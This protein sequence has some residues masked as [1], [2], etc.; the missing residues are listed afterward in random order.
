MICLLRI[1][2]SSSVNHFASSWQFGLSLLN[3][4]LL[5][6]CVL[7]IVLFLLLIVLCF[8]VGGLADE[9]GHAPH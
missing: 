4:C 6:I 1:F 7:L 3:F 9:V 8:V 2:A 5:L